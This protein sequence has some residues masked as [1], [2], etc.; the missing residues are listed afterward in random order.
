MLARLLL[1]FL[2]VAAASGASS[3]Q[4][5]AARP[6]GQEIIRYRLVDHDFAFK[7]RQN[8]RWR[9]VDERTLRS[10]SIDGRGG[11]IG[12][13]PSTAALRMTLFAED[14][15]PGATLER[16]VMLSEPSD[17]IEDSVEIAS[18]DLMADGFPARRI[19]T[20][21]LAAGRPQRV[22]VT[23][24]LRDTFLYRIIVQGS[25]EALTPEVG[26][27]V[28]RLFSTLPEVPRTR[29]PRVPQPVPDQR[30]VDWVLE[31]GTYVNTSLGLAARALE[32]WRLLVGLEAESLDASA[33][34][35]LE[36]ADAKAYVFVD[37]N[38]APSLAAG[39]YLRLVLGRIE[40]ALPLRDRWEKEIES[41]DGPRHRAGG[42]A[43]DIGFSYVIEA[44]TLGGLVVKQIHWSL[45]SAP[46]G[47]GAEGAPLDAIRIATDEE[48]ERAA[49]RLGEA[50]PDPDHPFDASFVRPECALRDG[51]LTAFDLGLRLHL[52]EGGAWRVFTEHELISEPSQLAV[53]ESSLAGVTVVLAASDPLGGQ[54]GLRETLQMRLADLEEAT[55]ILKS[56]PAGNVRIGG[57]DG[58]RTRIRTSGSPEWETLDLALVP[59]L[60]GTRVLTVKVIG[61]DE[62]V[63]AARPAVAK[64]L[65]GL[66][67]RARPL[68]R[69]QSLPGI[70][71]DHAW[72]F[73][74]D[75][76]RSA[77]GAPKV[78]LLEGGITDTTP[79]GLEGTSLTVKAD[80]EEA[81]L[82]LDAVQVGASSPTRLDALELELVGVH[83]RFLA[84][85]G[86]GLMK[87]KRVRIEEG[88]LGGLPATVRNYGPPDNLVRV[89]MVRRGQTMFMALI[90]ATEERCDAIAPWVSFH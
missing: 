25:P 60:D 57:R 22:D 24:I 70:H 5:D 61:P 17:L 54:V 77:P 16:G 31:G 65:S 50:W 79:E 2:L 66:E 36:R 4:D 89:Y 32:G 74:L 37:A 71:I 41:I 78:A 43:E 6:T 72:G 13:H 23:V 8:P 64:L 86:P 47:P 14:L 9:L 34:I 48:L 49:A 10:Q 87:V 12:R 20:D 11:L 82:Q 90:A 83:E 52:P 26:D 19:V 62:T 45:A 40:S 28:R 80:I 63:K 75:A 3:P 55:D 53:L 35:G 33:L 29:A 85:N 58:L 30:G 39:P 73:T 44:R 18:S 46:G 42:I 88:T 38:L 76:R 1:A 51:R 56:G 69:V 81:F 21:G 59:L 67:L 68:P 15:G 84:R 7:L 27:E